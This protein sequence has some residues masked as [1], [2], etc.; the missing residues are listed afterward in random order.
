MAKE[1]IKKEVE[2]TPVDVFITLL[3]EQY[4]KGYFTI[5]PVMSGFNATIE[6]KFPEI[7]AREFTDSLVEAG[8]AKIAKR[9]TYLGGK[10]T[11]NFYLTEEGQKQFGMVP[12]K[13]KDVD[14][15]TGQKVDKRVEATWK[16]IIASK[17][18]SVK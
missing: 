8:L 17:K 3:K 9:W 14:V 10:G 11:P 1:T 12:P 16:K 2:I 15:K 13:P 4:S 18:G 5:N 7:S 6:A